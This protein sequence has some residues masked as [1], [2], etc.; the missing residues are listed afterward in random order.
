MGQVI[1]RGTV[2][3]VAAITTLTR[4]AYA[5]WVP[6]TGREPLP[7]RADYSAA[8]EDH[9]FDLLFI[10]ADLAA[11]VETVLRDGDLLIE[12]VA[13]APAFQ[14]RGFGRLLIAHA[15]RMAAQAG[16][17]YVR[18]YTNSR[19]EENLRLYACRGA[20]RSTEWWYSCPHGQVYKSAL[21]LSD[22][23]RCNERQSAIMMVRRCMADLK[24]GVFDAPLRG[25]GA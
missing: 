2:S 9:R 24:P 1:R 4:S 8:I 16:R 11:L 20:R 21:E 19:F 22:S 3:D 14:K 15:E 25:C 5:K 13:V 18:L 10:D 17:A 12:N 7:M 23:V 6:L